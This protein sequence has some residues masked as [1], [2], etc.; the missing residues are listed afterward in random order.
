[1]SLAIILGV[2]GLSMGFIGM[3]EPLNRALSYTMNL[4]LSN[5]IPTETELIEMRFRGIIDQDEY[6]FLMQSLG[7]AKK[8]AERLYEMRKNLLTATENL[9]AYWK[10]IIS[11]EEF[12]SNM[13]KLGFDDKQIEIYEKINRFYPSPSDFI[14]FA[15][16]DVY[17]EAIVGKYGYDEEFPE[18]IVEDVKKI[19]MDE[20]WIKYY[21]RAHWDLPSPTQGYEMLHRLNPDV[22]EVRGRAYEEMGLKP[23][24]I[25]TD[26]DTI[27]ELLKIADYPKYWR[28]RLIAIA[29]S[30]ITRVDLRRIYELGLIDRKELVARLQELGYTKSDAEL[31]AVFFDTLKNQEML[32]K[33]KSK[34]DDLYKAGK[35]TK[36]EMKKYLENLGYSETEIDLLITYLDYEIR[37]EKT[38]EQLKLI[39]TLFRKGIIDIEEVRTKL[40]NLGIESNMIDYYLSLWTTKKVSYRKTLTKTDIEN[41]YKKKLIDEQKC[42]ELLKK[43]NYTDEAIDLL[44]KLWSVE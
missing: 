28:D 16:R 1:M 33:V 43:L 9:V 38:K 2:I 31:L 34:L 26:L 32:D 20:K 23:E 40:R 42:R 35:I 25:K 15:V 18:N 24:E 39:E 44:I 11:K 5:R 7:Y 3:T 8:Q 19:G 10:G 14:H 29:Y 17:N 4:L 13:K 21:W 27:R 37:E 41:L 36:D 6:F 22:L 12:E 30:P